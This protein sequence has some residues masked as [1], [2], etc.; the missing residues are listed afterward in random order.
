MKKGNPVPPEVLFAYGFNPL[1]TGI[2]PLGKGLIN[3]TWKIT[4]DKESYVL[5]KL[6]TL[7]FQSPSSVD[8]NLVLL[9]HYFAGA[10]PAYFFT[11]P[12]K[13]ADG[14]TLIQHK[15]KGY[16][17]MFTF[18]KGSHTIDV[19]VTPQ[20]A[21]EA[22]KQFGRFTAALK[23][24]DSSKLHSTIPHFHD[25]SFRYRQFSDALQ[26]GN[27][28]RIRESEPFIHELIKHRS[29]VETYEA[30]KQ[31]PDFKLRATHHDTKISNVLFDENEKGICVIDLDTLMPGYFISDVGDMMRTYLS[32][33]NEE[34]T[35]FSKIQIRAEYYNAIVSGYLSE[36]ETELT[37][38]EK[39]QLHFAGKF[40]IYMQA[41]R[42]L[43]DYLMDDVYYG[44]AYPKHNLKRSVNQ[45]QLLNRFI[46]FSGS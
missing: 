35:D 24:F 46:E 16:Y 21:Y 8:H 37:G 2:E 11:A 43:T 4:V 41:L 42:F 17:R 10:N 1:S 5:Q 12:L 33:V 27:A 15:D 14:Q 23:D 40:M 28:E 26:N 20:Q 45:I 22:A 13:S 38:A 30:L 25:L 6:N 7:V 44:A 9:A 31:N 29:I 19:A 39:E 18:V 34:E 36:M 32:P 3:T